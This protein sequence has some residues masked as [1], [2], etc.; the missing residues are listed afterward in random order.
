MNEEARLRHNAQCRKRNAWG[1]VNPHKPDGRTPR[2]LLDRCR[3]KAME[4]GLDPGVT[5]EFKLAMIQIGFESPELQRSYFHPDYL[6]LTA[7]SW[8]RNYRG[9]K[10]VRERIWMLHKKTP[11]D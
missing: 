2:E 8:A 1:N 4:M 3:L 11:V 6:A 9:S 10:R 5:A 7:G